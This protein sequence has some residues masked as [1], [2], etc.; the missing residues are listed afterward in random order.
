MHVLMSLLRL[1]GTTQLVMAVANFFLPK[2]LNYRDNLNRVAP[3][4][5][6]IFIVH[7]AYIV[8][9]LLLFATISFGFAAELASGRGLGQF[10]AGAM[11]V[12]WVCRVPVQLLYYD[13]AVRRNHRI[14]DLAFTVATIFL[15]ATYSAAAIGSGLR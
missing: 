14:G 12:F 15:A 8:G 5:R 2:K 13:R 9:V 10:L 11:A 1:A 6:E 7:S 4:I 3:I